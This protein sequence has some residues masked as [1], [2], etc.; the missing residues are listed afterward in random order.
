MPRKGRKRG[1][2]QRGQ[3]GKKDA[4][5][6]VRKTLFAEESSEP[7]TGTA[8]TVPSPNRNRT[9]PNRGLPV[10]CQAGMNGDTF[11]IKAPKE[12]SNK[13][14]ATFKRKSLTRGNS[15]GEIK[16]S[17]STV[18]ALFSKMAST[19]QRIAMVDMAFLVFTAFPYLP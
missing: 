18:A 14:A 13:F 12:C 1:G 19:G 6:Q 10:I 17:T 7:K 5:K 4:R 9:E 2:Q 11:S 8:G 15:A 3:K 16:V